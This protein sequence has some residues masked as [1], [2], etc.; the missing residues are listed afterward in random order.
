MKFL[1]RAAPLLFLSCLPAAASAAAPTTCNFAVTMPGPVKKH[2]G[3]YG[4]RTYTALRHGTAYWATCGTL[5]FTT[6]VTPANAEQVL[7]GECVSYAGSSTLL[8][9]RKLTVQGHPACEVEYRSDDGQFTRDRFI[10][11]GSWLYRVTFITRA[12][13]PDAAEMEAYISSFHPTDQ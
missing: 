2:L 9:K 11:V 10:I 3:D 6:E 1:L 13:K 4:G 12:A 5:A 8:S 7:E